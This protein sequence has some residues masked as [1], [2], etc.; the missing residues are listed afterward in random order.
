MSV[1][2]YSQSLI[3]HINGLKPHLQACSVRLFASHFDFCFEILPHL[4]PRK[5]GPFHKRAARPSLI[6]MS[7]SNFKRR[8]KNSRVGYKWALSLSWPIRYTYLDHVTFSNK[9][10][11]YTGQ[12]SLPCLQITCFRENNG[13]GLDFKNGIMEEV[14]FNFVK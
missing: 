12:T 11:V 8:R 7:L 4:W 3:S 1:D 14:I 6:I 9:V 13:C 2:L 5:L 10:S